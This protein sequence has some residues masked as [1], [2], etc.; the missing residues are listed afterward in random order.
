MFDGTDLSLAYGAP[1]SSFGSDA[2]MMT[3]DAPPPPPVPPAPPASTTPTPPPVQQPDIVYNPAPPPPAMFMQQ[4]APMYSAHSPASAPAQIPQQSED[5]IWDRISQ[6]KLDVLKLF[7]LA[8]VILLGISIDKVATH[9]II[10]YINNSVLT[11]IQELLVRV[12][13]PIIVLI[14]LWLIKAST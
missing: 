5:T 9:Y 13:Y 3:M 8:L 14:I 1:S 4:Q 11:N 7:I 10:T 6:R 12:S 2:M